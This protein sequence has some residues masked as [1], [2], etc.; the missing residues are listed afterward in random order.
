M[1]TVSQTGIITAASPSFTDVSAA[2]AQASPGNTV[3][4]PAGTATWNDHLVIT[5]GINMIG[6][7]KDSTIITSNY[8]C[9]N[10]HMQPANGYSPAQCL[11]Q[12]L[13]AYKPSNP[14]ANEPFQL[15]GFTLDLASKCEGIMIV[16]YVNS[17]AIT[18]VRVDNNKIINPA[19]GTNSS[20]P[21]EFGVGIVMCVWGQVYGVVDNNVI[22]G[23]AYFNVIGMNEYNWTNETFQFG[24][25]SNLYFEDN[26]ITLASSDTSQYCIVSGAGG[27]WCFRYNRIH[28]MGCPPGL[29]PVLDAHGNNGEGG[30]L[31][32]MGCEA[33]SNTVDIGTYNGRLTDQRGGRA[34]VYNNNIITSGSVNMLVREEY[35]DSTSPPATASDGETQHVC[36]SYY[37]SNTKNSSTRIDPERGSTIDYGGPIGLVPQANRDFW[38]QGSSFNGTTGVGV[39]PLASRPSTCTTGVA[40]WA[41]DEG[42]LYVATATNIWTLYYTPYAYPHP[43]R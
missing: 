12:Y 16:N 25:A 36:N 43:L 21:W 4:V 39:G 42:K 32:L 3:L 31:S 17:P 13:I 40:Y 20:Y 6:A 9:P 5:K 24:S 19:V 30:N 28:A 33:Y 7:G 35:L 8:Y 29:W 34:L 27:R 10:Q 23:A 14:N 26:D 22:S 11:E 15:S 1:I 18:N 41:I 38:F 2:I 37:W